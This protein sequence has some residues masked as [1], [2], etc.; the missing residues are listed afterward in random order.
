MHNL[1]HINISTNYYTNIIYNKN[2]P[3]LNKVKKIKL[4]INPIERL[5]H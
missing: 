5:V 4:K 2:S 1:L 3:N